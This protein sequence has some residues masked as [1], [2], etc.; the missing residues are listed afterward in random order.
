[1]SNTPDFDFESLEEAYE[2]DARSRD[3]LVYDEALGLYVDPND[4]PKRK[5]KAKNAYEAASFGQRAGAYIIDYIII[6]VAQVFFI[7]GMSFIFSDS[8]V[9][10]LLGYLPLAMASFG[11]WIYMPK[12][13]NGQTIGKS[14][15]GIRIIN[16]DGSPLSWGTLMLRNWV[17]YWLS[18]AILYIGFLWPLWDDED[19]AL[20]DMI[21]TT[22]VVK[23]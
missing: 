9:G 8:D 1:M 11:L 16:K 13:N 15:I 10:A 3:G 17:G 14:L 23:A 2:E 19:R 18:G 6:T 21:A 20:H 12:V 4:E 7:G 5:P 22:Y